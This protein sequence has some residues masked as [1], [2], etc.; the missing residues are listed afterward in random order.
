MISRK[1]LYSHLERLALRTWPAETA[2]SSGSWL[3]SG[4]RRRNETSQQRVDR[5]R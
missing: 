1:S 2:E 5:R 3:A 4:I